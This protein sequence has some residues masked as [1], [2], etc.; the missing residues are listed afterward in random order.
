VE[1]LERDL[2]SRNS[3]GKEAELNAE[4]LLKENVQLKEENYRLK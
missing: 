2:Q 1:R 4:A 3:T